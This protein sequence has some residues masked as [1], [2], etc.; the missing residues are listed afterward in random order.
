MQGCRRNVSA[1]SVP[2]IEARREAPD[3]P[4][5]VT[6]DGHNKAGDAALGRHAAGTMPGAGLPI[7]TRTGP[8]PCRQDA[9][10]F[11]REPAELARSVRSA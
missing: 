6:P 8:A 9:P 5:S 1:G 3:M 10:R 2:E 4:L 7:H 11:N